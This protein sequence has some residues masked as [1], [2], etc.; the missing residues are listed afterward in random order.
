MIQE[1][2]RIKAAFASRDKERIAD[3]FPFPI[4]DSVMGTI[5]YDSTA[6]KEFNEKGGR[7]TRE[8]FIKYFDENYKYLQMEQINELF[9]YLDIDK[10]NH[11]DTLT[12]EVRSKKEPCY[13]YYEIHVSEDA[14]T[15]IFGTNGNSEYV[16]PEKKSN[17]DET[18]GDECEFASFWTFKFDGKKLHFDHQT[19]AG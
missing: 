17:D 10:L 3:I 7:T 12:H 8:M 14:V 1:L 5:E 18:I 4:P 2:K 13:K 11:A 6:L 9:K 15:F 16:D 19:S